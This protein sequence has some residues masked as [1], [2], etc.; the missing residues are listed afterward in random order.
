[1]LDRSGQ[2][3]NEFRRSRGLDLEAWTSCWASH[4]QARHTHDRVQLSLT[5]VGSGSFQIK[6]RR[7]DS[8][9]GALVVIP[10]GEVHALSP[11]KALA[12]RFD[13]VYLPDTMC[14]GGIVYWDQAQLSARLASDAIA[15]PELAARFVRLHRAITEGTSTLTQEIELLALVSGLDAGSDA[16]SFCSGGLGPSM[17]ALRRVRDYLESCPEEDISLARLAAIANLSPSHLSH[18]FRFAF[19]L[20]P[21]AYLVQVRVSRARTLLKQGQPVC[22]VAARSGFADQAHLTRHFKRLVGVTPGRYRDGCRIV[23]DRKQ[24]VS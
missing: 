19:G 17:A 9:P 22:E 2:N 15:K 11:V 1:V 13:T 24:S 7:T 6:G 12:W 18:T 23:Q 5:T 20:P 10:S 16:P 14:R 3:W 21:H 8:V 4:V